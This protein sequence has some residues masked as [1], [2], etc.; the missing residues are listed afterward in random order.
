MVK[1]VNSTTAVV[2]CTVFVKNVKMLLLSIDLE[3]TVYTAKCL[4]T[5]LYFIAGGKVYSTAARERAGD[6][7]NCAE[8]SSSSTVTYS[9]W[10]VS[11]RRVTAQKLE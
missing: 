6:H 10:F 1:V 2:F 11:L 3:G 9:S 4:A 7:G 5:L 8:N